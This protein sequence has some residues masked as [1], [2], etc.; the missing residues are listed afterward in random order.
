MR[1]SVGTLL[2]L[3]AL[4]FAAPSDDEPVLTPEQLAQQTNAEYV[5]LSQ[6]LEELASRNAWSGVERAFLGILATGVSPSFD[7][8]V[9]GAHAA[10]AVGD[11]NAVRER[12]LLDNGEREDR[13]VIDWL[14]EIDSNY[15]LVYLA[16]DPGEV[17]LTPAVAPFN[18]DHLAA[19][20]FA[21]KQIE[22]SGVYEGYLPAGTYAFAS[23]EV[24]VQPRVSSVRIDLSSDGEGKKK[25]K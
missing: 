20:Q 19:V 10:R 14:F 7:D 13:T 24:Q 8:L 3:P 15:G 5:R 4:A 18:P 11:V 1:L 21:A 6:D 25:K 2:L 9:S 17:A 16:G 23:R 12:L 22:Q